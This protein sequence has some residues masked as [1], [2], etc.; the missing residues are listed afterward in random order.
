MRVALV[1]AILWIPVSAPAQEST[2]SLTGAV[3]DPTG[4]HAD[5]ELDSG[6]KK[7]KVQATIP[8]TTNSRICLPENML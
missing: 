3:V 4:A 5:V 2:A 1:F 6:T 7:Y 8:G